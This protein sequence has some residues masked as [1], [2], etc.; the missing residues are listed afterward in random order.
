MHERPRLLCV[1]AHPDDETLGMGGTLAKYAAEGA[2]VHV[3]CATRGE[4]GRYRDGGHHPGPEALG[5][6]REAELRAAARELGVDGVEI[7]GYRDGALD[8]ADPEE[9]SDRIAERLRRL[10][11]DVVLTFGPDGAYGHPDHIAIS[12]LTTAAVLRAAAPGAG[13]VAPHRV[14]KLYYMAWPA[15]KW[16]AFQAA[17]KRL[18]VTVDGREREALPWPD[19]AI[20]TRLD[21][22]EHR[23]RVRRAVA[24]HE[25][26]I[27]AYAL[28]L[29]LPEALQDRLWGTQEFYRALSLVN[30][31]REI[32]TDLFQGLRHP[33]LE[34]RSRREETTALTLPR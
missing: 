31:G 8:G 1:T 3:L 27:S 24:R 18:V 21:T 7:L 26:Q 34:H 20:T 30:G 14:P 23:E 33:A 29:E 22:R 17:Y 28:L 12:Q 11:P 13:G 5:R 4:S 2:E 19:W 6:I 9:A 25:T 32:E 16:T 10:R 15:E